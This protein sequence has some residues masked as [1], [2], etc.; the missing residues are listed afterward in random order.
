MRLKINRFKELAG[1][2]ISL[3]QAIVSGANGAGK[4]TILEA[5]YFV[6][7]GKKSD[8]TVVG[9]E[10][11]SQ[12]AK[13][14]NELF[15][16]V[17]LQIDE[18][19]KFCRR[20]EGSEK[21]A[22]GSVDS[23]LVR[24]INTTLFIEKGGKR[25]IV[26]Q[27]EWNEQIRVYFPENWRYLTNPNFL[28]EQKQADVK[29]FVFKLLN[30]SE[31]DTTNKD[32]AKSKVAEV[33]KEIESLDILIKEYEKVQEP[34]KVEDL[35][36][37]FNAKIADLRKKINVPTLSDA[38][39]LHNSKI[40]KQIAEIQA[41]QPEYKDFEEEVEIPVLFEKS[42][43]PLN[44]VSEIEREIENLKNREFDNSDNEVALN[45]ALAQNVKK[46]SIEEKIK[47]Y[48][49]IKA[50]LKC[51]KCAVCTDLFCEFREVEIE[52]LEDL[53]K[54]N[55]DLDYIDVED[56]KLKFEAEKADFETEKSNK[57]AELEA[58][59]KKLQAENEKIKAKNAEI[60]AENNKAINLHNE[61]VAQINEKNE[62]IRTNN[63]KIKAE[64]AK[65]KATFEAEK[66]AKLAELR[67][68]IKYPAKVDNS[69]IEAEISK[70]EAE[71]E[72][73]RQ[74][75]L[76]FA[77]SL[78]VYN[79]AQKEIARLQE[80][81]TALLATLVDFEQTY[82]IEKNKEQDFYAKI[83]NQVNSELSKFGIKFQ[84]Y[85]KLISS[86]D[87]KADFRIILNDRDFN[88]NGEA[89][90]QKINLCLFFQSRKNIVLPIFCDE[91]T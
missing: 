60:K 68:S 55:E 37:S 71:K 56:L 83:E 29:D 86:D 2:E 21:R 66:S 11:Y 25:D 42:F 40:E 85:R 28:Q 45:F 19:T 49:S 82:I 36:E 30:L 20:C 27:N 34:A 84:L 69:E 38:D 77:K 67:A 44:D 31:F 18:N 12:Y 4:T 7:D 22:K 14:K 46:A 9:G 73:N 90:I 89:F 78:A 74:S 17:E 6:V 15:A 23:Y 3:P 48:D 76:D 16:E 88:S 87:F 63:E 32:I 43:L 54:A 50:G 58:E 51:T 80:E 91:I 61:K 5:F 64:N 10:I 26:T 13:T 53:Q 59:L 57:I 81:K 70:L 8:G 47:N 39:V 62:Q 79:N 24:N 35:T 41:Q 1:K 33:K 52:S 65:I 75:F 72:E